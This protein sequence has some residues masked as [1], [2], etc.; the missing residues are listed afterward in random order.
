MFESIRRFP[1]LLI[2]LFSLS[3]PAAAYAEWNAGSF[4]EL[5]AGLDDLHLNYSSFNSDNF[6]AV[7]SFSYGIQILA[8]S[9]FIQQELGFISMEPPKD[10]ILQG[11]DK[12]RKSLFKGATFLMTRWSLP[13]IEYEIDEEAKKQLNA[14]PFFDLGLGAEYI[15]IPAYLESKYNTG[16]WFG[17]RLGAGFDFAIARYFSS[18][19]YHIR[20]CTATSYKFGV[21]LEYTLGIAG[22]DIFDNKVAH[23]IGV[24][25]TF[26][27]FYRH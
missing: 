20:D 23:F 25:L 19:A 27:Y 24:N 10:L 1:V 9:L 6:G 17:V 16:A 26:T 12:K 22:H 15:E 2:L 11:K 14:G 3:F 21:S 8:F 7:F 4:L 5:S 18:C 13:F